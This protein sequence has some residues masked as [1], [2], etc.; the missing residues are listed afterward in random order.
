MENQFR[1]KPQK[2]KKNLIKVQKRKGET[3]K[4]KG[5]KERLGC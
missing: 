4:K 3:Y 2:I 1:Q 5:F